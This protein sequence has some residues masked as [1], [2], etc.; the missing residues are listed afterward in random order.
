MGEL[1]ELSSDQLELIKRTVAKNATDDELKLF[2]YRCKNLELDP[3]KPGQIYF[4]K[5][6][7]GPGTVVVGLDGFRSQ[8]AKTG[9]HTGTER[10]VTR[11][12]KG[13][14]IGAWCKVYRVDWTHPAT[15]EVSRD[16]YD[17]GKAMWQRMPETMLKK[18]AECAA[19]RMAF[20]DQLGGVYG[21]AEM[22]QAEMPTQRIIEEKEKI[23]VFPSNQDEI[24][25]L[26]KP[27]PEQLKGMMRNAAK[28]SWSVEDV[29]AFLSSQFNINESKDITVSQMNILNAIMPTGNYQDVKTRYGAN[30]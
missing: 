15:E 26:P 14:C 3:L 21:D 24:V 17:T 16:E 11:N 5:Y 28:Y 27:T 10:G 1:T 23:S 19:L 18:V 13:I 8:A 20:P 30:Q 22:Q 29:Q 4:V 6:G 9:K 2:L 25:P 7:N 12:D